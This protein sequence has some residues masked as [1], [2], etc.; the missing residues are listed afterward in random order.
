MADNINKNID[1]EELDLEQLEDV[2][3]GTYIPQPPRTRI[4]PKCG[5]ETTVRLKACTKCGYVEEG[6]AAK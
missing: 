6:K 4:C 2:S 3:G 1:N 5:E